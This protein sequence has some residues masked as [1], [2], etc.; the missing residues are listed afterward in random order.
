MTST[1]A[2][3][4]QP[5]AQSATDLGEFRDFLQAKVG[6]DLGEWHNLHAFSI[7][8]FRAF[9]EA[10]L[11]WSGLIAI[12]S[13]YPV[14]TGDEIASAR[15]FPELRLNYTENLL[16]QLPGDDSWPAIREVNEA[17]AT[18]SI[19]RGELRARVSALAGG[20]EQLGIGPGDHVAAIV[21]NTID[22]AVACL[23]VT[24]RGAVWSALSPDLGYDAIRERFGQFEPRLLVAHGQF[25]H[26]GVVRNVTDVLSRLSRDIPS[27]AGIIALDGAA[28]TGGCPTH[29]IQSLSAAA[30]P[31]DGEHEW[32]RVPFD[33][34]LFVLYSS[35]TTGRPKAIVH[36]V[37]GTLL[38]HLKEHRL[39]GDLGYGDVMLYQ[40][41]C[42]WMMWNW[43]LSGLGT[44]AEIVVYDGSVTYPEPDSLLVTALARGVTVF[45]TNPTYLQMLREASI[46]PRTRGDVSGVRSVLSTGSVLRDDLHEWAT[47][48]FG[49]CLVQSISG[50][51]DIIGCFVLGNPELPVFAGESQC[52][53]LGLDVRAWVDDGPMVV[54]TGELVC[55]TPFPSRP[56]GFLNDPGGERM[57]ASYFD[58]HPCVWTHGDLITLTPR[59]TARVLGRTDGVLNIRGVRIGPA[60]IYNALQRVPEVSEALAVEQIDSREPGGSRL[61]LLLTMATGKSLDRKLTLQLKKMLATT[62]SVNHVPAVIA[63]VTD[64]PQTFSGKVSERAA[65]DVLNGKVPANLSSLR[66]PASLAAI[67][68]HPSLSVATQLGAAESK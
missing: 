6:V 45:G 52:L 12:G 59:N 68:R 53:S 1:L 16:R 10:F 21:R 50:G 66:N 62:L 34:P 24:G 13:I 58:Q 42:G 37:G 18:S 7:Q 38:E 9:W 17:G 43:L 28:A 22:T 29:T 23:A 57:R 61:V 5:P 44:G 39:H 55:C 48:A 3:L 65:R 11:D 4:W 30:K 31:G 41:T 60:E 35:G 64:L 25:Q 67:S 33:H 19:S 46:E 14:C 32:P 8:H 40:T 26:H 27:I 15:F 54:G 63:E 51:T 36:G 2:P 56:V 47:A 20:L 49:G